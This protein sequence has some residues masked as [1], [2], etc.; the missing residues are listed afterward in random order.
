MRNEEQ[1][2]SDSNFV[3]CAAGNWHS[4]LLLTYSPVTQ[5]TYLGLLRFGC[6]G[7]VI[8]LSST[9]SQHLGHGDGA[10]NKVGIVVQALPDLHV[11]QNLSP[12][13]QQE[14]HSSQ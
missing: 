10:S 6:N 14:K 2:P 7:A 8:V 5:A 9:V 3:T 4:V 12:Q 13:P 11:A 1:W